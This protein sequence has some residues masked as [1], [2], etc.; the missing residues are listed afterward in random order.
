[1][2]SQT[3]GCDVGS[4]WI[5]AQASI[6]ASSFSTLTPT[7]TTTLSR[8]LLPITKSSPSSSPVSPSIST[9]PRPSISNNGTSS[10]SSNS[11]AKTGVAKWGPIVGGIA[12]GVFGLVLLF[13]LF[14]WFR[15]RQTRPN[16]PNLVVS[17]KPPPTSS[18]QRKSRSQSF[19]DMFG[20]GRMS[21]SQERA[22]RRETELMADPYSFA[23]PRPAP[24]APSQESLRYTTTQDRMRNRPPSEESEMSMVQGRQ[25]VLRSNVQQQQESGGLIVDHYDADED[26]SVHQHQFVDSPEP[27]SGV[28][29]GYGQKA[30]YTPTPHSLSQDFTQ[31]RPYTADD[32]QILPS[33]YDPPTGAERY[34]VQ[35][36][37]TGQTL[38]EGGFSPE[39]RY[40]VTERAS[41]IGEALGSGRRRDRHG[42]QYWSRQELP[43]LP[44]GVSEESIR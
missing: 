36:D 11:S 23:A 8:S 31:P 21:M 32:S 18:H 17:Y 13:L 38:T 42:E 5:A 6:S 20:A 16:D 35:S 3:E 44:R 1:M 22:N 34:T 7:G 29:G 26:D 40:P 2:Q 9:P 4:R 43:P 27:Q 30:T 28:G 37:M 25:E 12:G 10:D 41:S 19:L 14:R 15:S 24:K 33:L 39:S